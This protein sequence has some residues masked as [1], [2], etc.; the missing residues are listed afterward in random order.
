[1]RLQPYHPKLN[2]TELT[3]VTVNNWVA[4]VIK[5]TD[6]SFAAITNEDWKKRCAHVHISNEGILDER[7]EIVIHVGDDID[8]RS[9]NYS[10]RDNGDG[11]ETS[12]L[13]SIP[14]IA[15][16]ILDTDE[17]TWLT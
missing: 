8:A 4:Y 10:S 14:G 9:E 17:D 11:D 3:W 6:E 7:L 5:L 2:P 12:G 13:P 1:L 16:L 15:P